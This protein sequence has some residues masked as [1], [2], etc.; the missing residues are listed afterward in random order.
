MNSIVIQE[1]KDVFER[2]R[3]V[4]RRLNEGDICMPS[5]SSD[6]VTESE[7]E[8]FRKSI[9][10]ASHNT[11]RRTNPRQSPH[12]HLLTTNARLI[13]ITSAAIMGDYTGTLPSSL[14]PWD[15]TSSAPK[16]FANV[17][18]RI[19]AERG[20]FR[21]ITESSLQD[22]LTTTAIAGPSSPSSTFSDVEGDDGPSASKDARPRA[23]QL[24][25][26]RRE[27]IQHIV[28]AQNETLLALDFVSLLLSKDLKQAESSMSPILK[29]SVPTG[30][31][32][33]DIWKGMPE[34]TERL[35]T[36]ELLARG[37]RLDGLKGA[38]DGLSRAEE[39]LRETVE[40]ERRYW[41]GLLGLR[42]QGWSVCRIP[43]EKGGLGVRYG[44][45]EAMGEFRGRGLAA[46]RMGT[47]GEVVL[48]KGL[49]REGKG[50]RVRI[51]RGKE[52]VGE[53]RVKQTDDDEA[54]VGRRIK[55]ARDSLFEE[56]LWHE[57]M[58]EGREL[59]SYGIRLRG[60][61]IIIPASHTEESLNETSAHETIEIDL[62]STDN[63]YN[64][65][66]P[67]PT[68][69]S[70][71]TALRL[72][73]SHTYRQRLEQRSQIPPPLSANKRDRPISQIIRP[74]LSHLHHRSATTALQTQLSALTALLGK[75]Q[76][77]MSTST[78]SS[79]PSLSD[80]TS[81]KSLMTSLTTRPESTTTIDL[82]LPSPT[83]SRS[84]SFNITTTTS[85]SPPFYG[86]SFNLGA[87][88][89][90]R[91][92]RTSSL[93]E[94]LQHV[95]L[96]VSSY[97]TVSAAEYFSGWTAD[98]RGRKV[99]RPRGLEVR[100]DSGEE[101]EVEVEQED[102]EG[103]QGLALRV[104]YGAQV[105]RWVVAEDGEER[106]WSE[107]MGEIAAKAR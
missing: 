66:T 56:E 65:A 63:H 38:A 64:P 46:L 85:F 31:L 99:V 25:A 88:H 62:V 100:G 5:E 22:E 103:G 26:A 51:M 29:Q 20:H 9:S 83:A 76:I 73:L 52:V 16:S 94:L 101:V 95:H 104:A 71:A 11:S 86:T 21:D 24:Q 97:L 44:F 30:S 107:V 41:D 98:R 92:Q 4:H 6:A 15:Q 42:E 59:G 55:M 37:K 49:G 106:A 82:T 13:F 78:S 45:T 17:L 57:A 79:L 80:T 60:D 1:T 87:S 27:V 33:M 68:A 12:I 105:V 61:T 102:G 53:S 91:E 48:D 28:S 67:D 58:R 75:A 43:R 93:Q 36:D 32:G 90:Q 50:L 34:D 7:V 96:L 84:E 40:K 19:Y 81:T 77:K 14:Q 2:L 47:E 10:H 35:K 8:S 89:L 74:L 23:E 39:R 54:D 3:R 72:L 69:N 18:G 70:I